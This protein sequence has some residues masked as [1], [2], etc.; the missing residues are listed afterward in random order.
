MIPKTIMAIT[1]KKIDKA[2]IPMEVPVS[3]VEING[4]AIPAVVDV[5]VNLVAEVPVLMAVAVPPPA[6][7]ARAQ[8]KVGSRLV[9]VETMTAVPAM[10]AKGTVIK[11][12]KWS[13]QGII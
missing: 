1:G 6:M 4:L 5:E 11:S 2:D 8:V 3:T 13:N 7:M 12:N 10:V 9:S